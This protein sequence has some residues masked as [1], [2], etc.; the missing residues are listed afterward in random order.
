MSWMWNVVRAELRTH[1]WWIALALAVA[2]VVA[3]MFGFWGLLVYAPINVGGVW[4][5]RH[6]LGARRPGLQLA[7]SIG[8]V[9]LLPVGIL[10]PA[11]TRGGHTLAE[12]TS[13]GS[14]ESGIQNETARGSHARGPIGGSGP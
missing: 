9:L 13:S 8:A 12:S 5:V 11:F 4:S 14:G 7:L 6:D 2:T 10:A 3:A 1:G